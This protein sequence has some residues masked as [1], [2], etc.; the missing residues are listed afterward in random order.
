[1]LRGLLDRPPPDDLSETVHALTDGNPFFVEEVV[2]A[3]AASGDVRVPG[4]VRDAVRRRTEL[5]SP[6]AR[7]ILELAA[8]IGRRFD[9][10][11]LQELADLAAAD[12]LRAIKELVA[13]QLL[14]DES[15]ERLFFPHALTREAV[16]ADLLR[17]E[18]AAMH[19]A[20]AEALE[21]RHAGALD[22]HL[23]D[24]ANHFSEAGA[25]PK[26]LHYTGRAGDRA[27]ALHTPRVAIEQYTRALAA[28]ERLGRPRALLLLA[29]AGAYET[30]GDFERARRDYE[31]PTSPTWAAAMAGRC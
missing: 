23:H 12:L 16:S 24:L 7:R 14:V 9:V 20:V 27:R 30:V 10:A 5:L 4:S 1:M 21:R 19:L 3:L 26:A 29:R 17:R 2:S 15:A 18:R 31:G 25:W 6:D 11:L 28:A 22:G 8:V 13:A